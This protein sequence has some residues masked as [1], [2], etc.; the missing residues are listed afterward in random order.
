MIGAKVW[1][2][3]AKY[4]M[5]PTI[6]SGFPVGPWRSL[7]L[8]TDDTTLGEA[9]RMAL[10]ESAEPHA[11]PPDR[12]RLF[13]DALLLA[14]VKSLRTFERASDVVSIKADSGAVTLIQFEHDKRGSLWAPPDHIH[15]LGVLSDEQ[16][17]A[18]IRRSYEELAENYASRG[19]LT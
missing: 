14:G 5:S 18:S 13:D 7:D 9:I 8:A 19:R 16:L 3:H 12:E 10:V 2:V 4:I 11:T 15:V 1:L 17:G 6:G